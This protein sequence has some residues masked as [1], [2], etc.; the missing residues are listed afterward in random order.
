MSQETTADK[1][2]AVAFGMQSHGLSQT[3]G[4]VLDGDV[5][6]R[7]V[8]A[9]HLQRIGAE[10]A[11]LLALERRCQLLTIAHRPTPITHRD[12]GMIVVGDDGILSIFTTDFDVRQPRGNDELFLVDAPFHE[13]HLVVLHERATHLNG[14][15]DVAKLTSTVA[16]HKQRVRVVVRD[17]GS[18]LRRAY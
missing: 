8:A 16:R 11:H 13:N 5:L 6:Q 10:G 2:Q 17:A 12:V 3:G 14:F 7:D 15:T 4:I 1:P 18:S 9:L